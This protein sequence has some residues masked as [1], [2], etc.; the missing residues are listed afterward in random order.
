[1]K[2]ATAR[3]LGMVG[4]GKNTRDTIFVAK[5]DVQTKLKW[6]EFAAVTKSLQLLK[7]KLLT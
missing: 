2:D 3:Q 5:T 7:R 4:V 6:E 1:L